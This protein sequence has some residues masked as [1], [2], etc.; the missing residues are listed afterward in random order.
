MKLSIVMPCEKDRVPLLEKTLQRYS[1]I[2]ESTEVEFILPSRS[3]TEMSAPGFNI[4][5][6]PYIYDEGVF[7]CS[8]A[9]NLGVKNSSYENIIITCPE[10][11]PAPNVL[12]VFKEKGRGNY[13][14]TAYDLMPDGSIGPLLV[15][16]DFR[17]ETPGL[18]FLALF[19]KEDIEFINGW[20][21][22]FMG[23]YAWEDSEYGD[24]FIRAGLSFE[25]LEEAL[26]YHQY[27][28]RGIGDTKMYYVNETKKLKNDYNEIIRPKK[29][30]HYEK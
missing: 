24:R 21:E 23:G 30:L 22:G 12:K 18:Y 3:L 28:K 8:M 13:L 5:V 2:I 25:I 20:D 11:I 26:A 17:G 4:K 16:K 27:H 29:G 15:S 10:V 9:L 19:K 6:I 1:E 7:N 14:C